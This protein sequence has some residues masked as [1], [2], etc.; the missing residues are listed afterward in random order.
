MNLLL[1]TAV[2]EQ[3]TDHVLYTLVITNV[4]MVLGLIIKAVVDYVNRVQDRLD[5]ESNAKIAAALGEKR[6]DEIL[7]ST[8]AARKE[9]ADALKV[10]NGH[11]EKIAQLTAQQNLPRE[12]IIVN[13]QDKPVH[14]TKDMKLP[15]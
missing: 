3:S 4:V 2:S 9:S 12:V 7:A 6:K 13:P 14:V 10:A 11:N 5:R 1:E 8:E 15:Q